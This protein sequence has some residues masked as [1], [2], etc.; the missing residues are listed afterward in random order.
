MV[1]ISGQKNVE[2]ADYSSILRLTGRWRQSGRRKNWETEG[3]GQTEKA[4]GEEK[5]KIEDFG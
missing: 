5:Q 1:M 4:A 3:N 2:R